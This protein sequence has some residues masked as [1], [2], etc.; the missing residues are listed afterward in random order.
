MKKKRKA[1]QKKR[2]RS[3]CASWK[4]AG[5][6]MTAGSGSRGIR[7]SGT[8]KPIP[9]GDARTTNQEESYLSTLTDEPLSSVAGN[10]GE[11]LYEFG[12]GEGRDMSQW[13][14]I[15]A[16]VDSAAVDHVIKDDTVPQVRKRPSKGSKE[17][18]HWWSASNHKIYNEGEKLIAF[19]TS[20]DKKRKIMFQVAKVGRTLVSVDKLSETDHNVV[21]NKNDPRIE[22]PNGEVIKLRRQ[23]KVYILDLWIRKAPFTGR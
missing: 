5:S 2:M 16:A 21:L 12:D 1:S 15:E 8:S 14:K 11:V 22:C 17:G 7:H 4:N 23:N 6:A 19:Q 3:S 13:M 20:C 18:K 9:H 10:S